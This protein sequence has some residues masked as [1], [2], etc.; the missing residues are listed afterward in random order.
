MHSVNYSWIVYAM[1]SA[2][3][4]ALVGVFG[5]IGVKHIDSTVAT[6]VRAVLMALVL[7]LVLWGTH[8]FSGM[9]QIDTKAL[10]FLILAGVAGALSWLAYFYALQKGPLSGV[11]V[12]DRMSVVLAVIAGWALFS[13]AITVKSIAGILFM[14]A[15]LILFIV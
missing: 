2:V 4:A 12:I 7:L 5:K 1:L 15:G 9:R 14:V 11:A 13:E 10:I 8:R 3:F 6:T